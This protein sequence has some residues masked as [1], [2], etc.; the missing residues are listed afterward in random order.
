MA[1]N[2]RMA[3]FGAEVVPTGA[4]ILHH[5]NTGALATVDIGTAIGVIYGACCVATVSPSC[6]VSPLLIDA[7]I[8][9]VYLHVVL[10]SATTRARTC[11]CGWT[12]R[13]HGFRARG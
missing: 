8:T 6:E 9:R 10:Q 2:K 4:N 7:H 12:R 3:E 11:M 1:I 13:G 5:C